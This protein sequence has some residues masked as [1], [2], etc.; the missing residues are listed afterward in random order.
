MALALLASSLAVLTTAL[1]A[2][3]CIAKIFLV[4][5]YDYAIARYAAGVYA[6]QG[7]ET[8]PKELLDDLIHAARV[9]DDTKFIRNYVQRRR[10]LK[11]ASDVD[12]D[13]LRNL[14]EEQASAY[15]Q[16]SFCLLLALSYR[17]FHGA[18]YRQYLLE[19]SADRKTVAS[20]TRAVAE[21]VP[22]HALCA[23]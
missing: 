14:T 5:G 21:H 22:G 10:P 8:F 19:R 18:R 16:A 11:Q 12:M 20:Q 6:L 7:D 1:I 13:R 3:L 2:M 17:T 23:A 9:L 4:K 15:F